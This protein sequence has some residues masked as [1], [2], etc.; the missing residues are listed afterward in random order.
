MTV[1]VKHAGCQD[2]TEMM[3]QPINQSVTN[4]TTGD[5]IG[6]FYTGALTTELTRSYSG[7]RGLSSYAVANSLSLR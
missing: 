4:F 6:D 7:T 5:N 3:G 2:R 1:E